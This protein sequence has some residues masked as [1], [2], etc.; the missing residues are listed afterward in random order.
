MTEPELPQ[1]M[2][3]DKRMQ[4]QRKTSS[5]FSLSD[6]L[7]SNGAEPKTTQDALR[8]ANFNITHDLYVQANQQHVRDAHTKAVGQLIQMPLREAV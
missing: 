5:C 2:Q 1:E 8:H 7:V 6:R 4:V 3:A